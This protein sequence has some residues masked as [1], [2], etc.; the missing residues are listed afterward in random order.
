MRVLRGTIAVLLLAG[1]LAP[2]LPRYAAER[3][4]R[5]VIGALQVV[6]TRPAEVPDP[7]AALE[8]ITS[9][10][11]ASATSLPG[12]SRP[13]LVAG[14]ARLAGGQLDAAIQTY[15]EALLSGERAETDLNL[16][17]A[18]EAEGDASRSHAAFL[19]AVWI[20]PALLSAVL[21][22]IA[23]ALRDELTRLEAELRAGRLQAP[24]PLPN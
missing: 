12:D 2:E 6:L 8:R 14:A 24:P 7:P 21:P 5:V 9:I 18:Y 1:A 17:R 3:T 20:N 10:A 16:G 19:R 11:A 13:L 4:L 23:A 22:D 15:R